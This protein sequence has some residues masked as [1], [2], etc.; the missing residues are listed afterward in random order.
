MRRP[1]MSTG[2]WIFTGLVTAAIVA[3]TAVYA[4]A[5]STV[6]IGNTS[7]TTTAT[8]TPQHQLLTTTIAP[9]DV[10]RT[11]GAVG[12]TVCQPV[13][14]PPAGK[15]VV[16]TSVT[17][18]VGTGT[19]GAAAYGYLLDASCGTIYDYV[20]TREASETQART[21]P[22]GLPMPSVGLFGGSG[23]VVIRAYITGYLIP[24][25]QLPAT[26]PAA[27]LPASMAR[28]NPSPN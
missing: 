2:A 12:G 17:F 24:A 8:V 18:D 9:R 13:Y 27:K 19:A 14:I 5:S 10:I 21:Y 11:S 26:A 3:P 4:A 25:G 16:L 20:D 22:I 6:A 15:A 1:Q 28:P 23:D 7:G